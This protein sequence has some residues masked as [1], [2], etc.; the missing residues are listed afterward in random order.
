MP[1]TPPPPAIIFVASGIF[2]RPG[3]SLSFEVDAWIC[4]GY[5]ADDI[6]PDQ[7]SHVALCAT[8]EICFTQPACAHTNTHSTMRYKLMRCYAALLILCLS[9]SLSLS[10]PRSLVDRIRWYNGGGGGVGSNYVG[11]R[12][13]NCRIGNTVKCGWIVGVVLWWLCVR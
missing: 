12:A 3:A 10:F 9:F 5:Q 13:L 4:W 2:Q 1:L 7:S 8:R 6:S 11:L